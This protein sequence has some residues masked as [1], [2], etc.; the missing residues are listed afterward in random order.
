MRAVLPTFA[1]WGLLLATIVASGCAEGPIPQSAWLNP[2]TRKQW[3]EDEKFGPTYYA[4]V[5]ELTKMRKSVLSYPPAER[6]RIAGLLATRLREE[7][8]RVLRE[9]VTR[10]L[11]AIPEQN[12]EDAL[13]AATTDQD[14][15]VRR[16]ACEGLAKRGS[17]AALEALARSVGSDTDQ[18]VRI[19]AARSLKNYKDPIAVRALGAALEENNSGMQFAVMD[20]LRTATG[21]DY[22]HSVPAWKEYLQGGNPSPPPPPSIAVQLQDYLWW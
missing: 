2:Y 18:E 14:P 13:L 17:P 10:T 5:D 20:S 21:K 22:G 7:R 4:K 19:A 12:A 15:Y 6:Q 3:E 9:E 8:S 16:V 11:A 1:P